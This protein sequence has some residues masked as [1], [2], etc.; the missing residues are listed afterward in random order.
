MEDFPLGTILN[1]VQRMVWRGSQLEG[2]RIQ[3]LTVVQERATDVLN[4]GG[5][6]GDKVA[7]STSR[8]NKTYR[9]DMRSEG[10]RGT[11]DDS[12]DC[13]LSNWVDK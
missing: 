5:D 13:G 10:K 9:F 11:K 8:T 1:A 3:N 6:S 2:G 7:Y 4:R 12:K